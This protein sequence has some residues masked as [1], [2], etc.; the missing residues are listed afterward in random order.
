MKTHKGAAKRIRVTGTGRY[1]VMT[2]HH[3][4]KRKK[5]RR[6]KLYAL[7]GSEELHQSHARRARRLLPYA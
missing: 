7:R 3:N 5:K 2:H 4:S 1:F 6:Q